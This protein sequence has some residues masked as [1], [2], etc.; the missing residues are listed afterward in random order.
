MARSLRDIK[1][2][3]NAT[4]KIS[5]ITSA[6]EMVSAAKLRR[7]ESLVKKY[8]PFL[9]SIKDVLAHIVG[10]DLE[11]TH[12]MLQKR[13]IKKTAYLLVTSD[14]GLNGS[15]NHN[16]YRTFF[17]DAEKR[18]QNDSEYI[19]S[20]LGQKGFNYLRSKGIKLIND[21]PFYVRDDIQFID[22]IELIQHIID[23]YI[24][25]EIDEV[26]VYYNKYVNK[27]KQVV[28]SERVLPIESIESDK[29]TNLIYDF[30]PSP[31]VVLNT[32]MPIYLQNLI[33]GLILNAKTSEHAARMNSMKNATE[34]AHEII[35]TL[36]LHYNRAR[37]Q[38]ITQEITEI[39]SGASALL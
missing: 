10:S 39:V 4:N 38:A 19:V 33:Y 8:Q 2:K 28:V 25:E 1:S 29:K 12:T 32:L 6:M 30:E 3:I 27:L 18:H 11:I 13:E 9:Q 21:R 20:V 14:R 22:F 31:R 23:L 37:Q 17:Q 34:N 24:D 16:I 7:A 26:V 5:Q 36:N 15:Y 35:D